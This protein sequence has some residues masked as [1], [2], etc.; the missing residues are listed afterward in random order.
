ML[1][2]KADDKSKRLVL[3]E[4]L[5]RSRML[6]TR[7]KKWLRDELDRTRKG[8]DGERESA[9]F[10]DQHF[11]DSRNNAVLH[12]LRLT[13]DGDVAQIDHLVI[14][15]LGYFLLIETKNYGGNVTINAH[16]EFTVEYGDGER[17]G[18][19]SPLEQS[20]RHERVLKKMLERLEIAPRV[21]TTFQFRHVVLF[22]PRAIIERPPSKVLD[23]SDVIKADQF[24]AWHEAFADEDIGVGEALLGLANMRSSETAR[25][26]GEKLARQHR[27]EDPLRLPEFMAPRQPEA[28]LAEPVEA[29]QSSA[30]ATPEK[31]LICLNC[32]Q[33]I[34]FAEGKFCWN[35]ERRFKGGQYCRERQA[36]F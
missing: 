12:D 16:G 18:V 15:R 27:P 24:R 2:K 1:L 30:P 29:G 14:N 20:R 28:K 11:K 8:I 32:R 36:L 21:G 31:K 25:E 23:T 7:Q 22:H 5:Q 34:S 19:A 35:N 13:S 10:L 33:K 9:Y 17:I 6:D 4:E 3:L 26:W